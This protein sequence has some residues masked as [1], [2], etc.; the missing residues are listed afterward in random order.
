MSLDALTIWV[1]VMIPAGMVGFFFLW[2]LYLVAASDRR[3]LERQVE[4]LE[5]RIARDAERFEARI[6]RLR[7]QVE[8]RGSVATMGR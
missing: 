3:Q 1:M 2:F 8:A 6:E 7:Q 4:R 5:E